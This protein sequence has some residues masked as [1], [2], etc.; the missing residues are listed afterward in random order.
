MDSGIKH[1]RWWL[2]G[3][4]GLGLAS[5]IQAQEDGS[6]K[7]AFEFISGTV[8]LSSPALGA[9]GTVY[10][11]AEAVSPTQSRLFAL[12]PGDG[13]IKWMVQLPDWIDSSPAVGED[14]TVYIGCWDGK[15]YAI[16]PSGSIRWEYDTGNF[17]Y[18]SPAIGQDGTIYVG[19]G[20]GDLHA[21]DSEGNLKWTFPTSNWVDSSPAVGPDGTIYVGSWDHS[22]YAV[23]ADGGLKWSYAT[24]GPVI[25]SPAIDAGG[26]VYVGSDDGNL[27]ALNSDGT[28]LWTYA[29]ED[30]VQS[31]PV[32]GE[33][34][35]LYVGSFDG[36]LYA[37]NPD[38]SLRWRYLVAGTIVSS[39][40]VRADGSIV[41][42]GGD[43]TISCL[44][45]DGTL[46]W[47]HE[48]G[49]WVDSSPAIAPDGSIYA[50]SFDN[51]VYALNG[52]H[53]LANTLWPSFHRDEK[54]TGSIPVLAP[55]IVV[56]PF[57]LVAAPGDR[58]M[59]QVIPEDPANTSYEWWVDGS[60]VGGET[61]A[62]LDF[63]AVGSG[64]A[65]SY[66]VRVYNSLGETWSDPAVLQVVAGAD[67][68]LANISTRGEVIG[69]SQIM[70][71][72]FVAQGTGSLSVLI[73]GVGPT[74]GAYGVDGFIPD[75]SLE[76]VGPLG[77][78]AVNDNWGEAPN[79]SEI[80][81][82]TERVGAFELV[83]GSLDAAF[84]GGVVAGSRYTATVT[85]VDGSAGVALVEVYEDAEET[86]PIRLVNISNRG[87]VGT[88]TK[89]MIPGFVIAEGVAARA[90]LIRGVGPTLADFEV[91]DTLEDPRLVLFQSGVTINVNDDWQAAPNAS[92]IEAAAALVGA[93]PLNDGSTD[94]AI[95]TVLPPGSYTAVVEDDDGGVGTALVEV[96]LVP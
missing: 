41:F 63:G 92:E 78:V 50:G 55:E 47:A 35:A 19:S 62:I 72:G 30:S 53:A 24:G 82:A 44:N 76:V 95:L 91:P 93:F 1:L 79:I 46:R 12:N 17:I 16:R 57:S 90:V 15:L 68:R 88:G 18:S 14:G 40:A 86:T 20:D 85:G 94:A 9:D 51:F 74:L 7:W 37:I 33:D 84:L 13:S 96:Y 21:I 2:F 61:S 66:L 77:S 81:A 48:T 87:T 25:S 11:G 36:N 38:G 65:G 52:D 23:D 54:N 45:E 29:A 6:Q 34:G 4:I 3:L 89:V 43:N 28:L 67:S 60:I 71:P 32:V 75:P 58:V 8:F 27:Y 22:I 59:L 10:I 69:E 73:R 64:D 31:S 26:N 5:M 42:G 83:G 56:Q 70:I 49:D 39:P 80:I